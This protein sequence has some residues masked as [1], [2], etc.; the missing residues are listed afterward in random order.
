LPGMCPFAFAGG[1]LGKRKL[2]KECRGTTKR[3]GVHRGQP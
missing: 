3:I 1:G 2:V